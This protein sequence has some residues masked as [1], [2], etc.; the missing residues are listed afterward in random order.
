M[1]SFLYP[2]KN[3]TFVI[4]IYRDYQGILFNI[5][6]AFILLIFPPLSDFLQSYN[7]LLISIILC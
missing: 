6:R 7:C 2:G 3:F 4:C 5:K 1:L